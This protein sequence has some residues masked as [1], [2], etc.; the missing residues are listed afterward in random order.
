MNR[1]KFL[2]SGN[3][4]D[5][6]S[7]ILQ[8]GYDPCIDDE[9]DFEDTVAGQAA[10]SSDRQWERLQPIFIGLGLLIVVALAIVYL[11]RR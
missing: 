6:Q 8:L 5:Q 9:I 1:D 11:I 7:I 2:C 4:A 10:G 3:Y